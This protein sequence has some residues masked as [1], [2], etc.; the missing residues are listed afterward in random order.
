MDTGREQEGHQRGGATGQAERRDRCM[1]DMAEEKIVD[2]PVPVSRELV[3]RG[4][5]PPVRVEASIGEAGQLGQDVELQG[6]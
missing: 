1:I 6:S 4:R 5:I 2:R 3:P